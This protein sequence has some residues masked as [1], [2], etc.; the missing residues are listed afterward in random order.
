MRL[1]NIKRVSK[2]YASR[3]YTELACLTRVRLNGIG[4]WSNFKNLPH[5]DW[6]ESAPARETAANAYSSIY[7][8]FI[9]FARRNLAGINSSGQ[10]PPFSLQGR[11]RKNLR[12][13]CSW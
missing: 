6:V 12:R 9:I 2:R 4:L 1:S 13:R 7:S 3:T 5:A 8:S 10:S 11:R